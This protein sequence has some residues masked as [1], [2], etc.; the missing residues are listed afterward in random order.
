MRPARSGRRTRASRRR[1]SRSRRTPRARA[2][3]CRAR[4][5]RMVRS[6]SADE[7]AR[8]QPLAA[9]HRVARGR[10]RDD[11]VAGGRVAVALACLGADLLAERF[12]ALL[13][14]A[15]GDCPPRSPAAPR[16][17]MRPACVPGTRSRSRRAS[18]RRPRQVLRCDSARRAG[19]ELPEPAGLDHGLRLA[20]LKEHDDE[21]DRV[22]PGRVLLHARKATLLVDGSHHREEARVEPEPVAGDVLDPS[23]GEP[24]ERVLDRPIASAGERS[25]S[26]SFSVSWSA[27]P[28]MLLR[29]AH[30]DAARIGAHDRRPRDDVPP[31][32]PAARLRRADPEAL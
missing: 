24:Q 30:D 13:V 1:A 2:R 16:G 6:S 27:R 8:L 19:A 15:V 22:R 10:H 32:V 31:E 20:V 9:Q 28:R 4:A 7:S 14:P 11:H 17:C 12:Q 21:R 26:T 5:P 3:C 25:R 29:V 18:A 23:V